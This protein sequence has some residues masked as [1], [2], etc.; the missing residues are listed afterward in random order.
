MLPIDKWG[1]FQCHVSFLVCITHQVLTGEI[2]RFREKNHPI[3][4]LEVGM[5]CQAG[6]EEGVMVWERC[7]LFGAG[8]H[9]G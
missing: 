5:F 3:R 9:G 8:N 7:F 2:T 1:I 4:N 6:V